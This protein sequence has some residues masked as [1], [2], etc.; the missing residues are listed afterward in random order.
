MKRFK[1][2]KPEFTIRHK[3]EKR[4]I[5]ARSMDVREL[6]EETYRHLIHLVWV[7]SHSYGENI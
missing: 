1:V 4:E 2:V 3:T 5:D 7:I 6:A